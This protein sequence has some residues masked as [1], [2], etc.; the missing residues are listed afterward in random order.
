M[1]DLEIGDGVDGA[2]SSLKRRLAAL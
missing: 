2:Y 1:T